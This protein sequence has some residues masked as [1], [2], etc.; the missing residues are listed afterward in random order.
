[1]AQR[2]L[3]RA[4]GRSVDPHDVLGRSSF[5]QDDVDSARGPLAYQPGSRFWKDLQAAAFHDPSLRRLLRERGID[6]SSPEKTRQADRDQFL[7]KIKPILMLRNEFRVAGTDVRQRQIRS[8]KLSTL[9]SGA[10]ALYA[11]SDGN[12][13]WL[14]GM[15]GDILAQ[16]EGQGTVTRSVQ[17]GVLWR[18]SHRFKALLGMLPKA[19]RTLSGKEV[20][21]GDVVDGVGKYFF[22][23]LVRE[24]FP[25][26]PVGSFI[27]DAKASEPLVE[28]IQLGVSQGALVYVET[29]WKIVPANPRGKRFRLSFML[30]PSYR[31]PLRL[32]EP[33]AL[34]A[35]LKE[36]LRTRAGAGDI[37]ADQA[38]LFGADA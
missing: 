31:L 36:G 23:R 30:A 2:T 22:E 6:P 4:F 7:R 37:L 16:A 17:A 15:L 33:V 10:E 20:A 25:I 11:L 26:D 5:A 18:A 28:L 14:I 27:V 29:D 19:S 1:L 12:P 34:S 32:Y 13:R 38:D 9:Y 3:S 35:C 21:L 8:R 24:S